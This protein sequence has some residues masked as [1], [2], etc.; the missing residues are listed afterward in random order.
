MSYSNK[1]NSSKPFIQVRYDNNNSSYEIRIQSINYDNSN[2][3][4]FNNNGDTGS[5]IIY[6]I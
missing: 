5:I 3:F 1:N 2:G 6:Y 4:N